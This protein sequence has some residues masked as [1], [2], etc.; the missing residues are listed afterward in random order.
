MDLP[1]RPPSRRT[2][3]PPARVEIIVM[4]IKDHCGLFGIYGSPDAV[5]QTYTGLF[6]QQHRGQESAGIVSIQNNS[7][8]YHKGMGLVSD[9]FTREKLDTLKGHAAIGHVRYSTTG[10]S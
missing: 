7:L 2:F 10:A 9:V 3:R 1:P 4:A 6:A 5:R 8:V